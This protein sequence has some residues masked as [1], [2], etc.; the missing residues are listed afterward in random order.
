MPEFVRLNAGNGS[1]PI[2]IPIAPSN[3][4]VEIDQ[5]RDWLLDYKQREASALGEYSWRELGNLIGLS[6]STL[7][8]FCNGTYAGSETNVAAAIDKFRKTVRSRESRAAALPSEPGYFVT[9]T[10]ER[11]TTLLATAHLGHIT[12]GATSPGTGKTI[13]AR[14]YQARH[15]NVWLATMNQSTRTLN[16]MIQEVAY[17][18]GMT[19]PQHTAL[20]S[21]AVKHRVAGR[22]GLIIIDEAN[23]LS[24]EAIEEIR[25][26][27]DAT[28]VGICLLGN[29][30]LLQRIQSGP[31]SDSYARLNG[32]LQDTHWQY[33]PEAGDVEAFC[34]HWSIAD[35]DMRDFLTTVALRPASGG[36]RECG[37]I[38]R[39]AS[40][41]A[42]GEKRTITLAD[43][44]DVQASRHTRVGRR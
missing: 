17:G 3:D 41:L 2:M 13:T 38:I 35:R 14:H 37:M 25:S 39:G 31:R 40:I 30:E 20:A 21:R 18:I 11:I 44:K 27:W 29:E 8:A 26:W 34:D 22:E 32:R 19:A 16:Q 42:M 5:T 36:L 33:A 43:L 1:S 6:A 9:P 10:S 15:S 23:V 24:L 28:K 4:P 7:T 12:V